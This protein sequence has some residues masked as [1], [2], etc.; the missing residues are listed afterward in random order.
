MKCFNHPAVDA[1][2]LCKNCLKAVCRDCATEMELGVVCRGGCGTSASRTSM[3]A[4]AGRKGRRIGPFLVLF[5][6]VA[7]L[8]GGYAAYAAI[9][10]NLQQQKEDAAVALGKSLALKGAAHVQAVLAQ[11]LA[12][13]R[14]SA[15]DV[16]DTNYQLIPA[17]DPPKYH[18]RFDTFLDGAIGEFQD[19]LLADPRVVF[20]VAVDRNGYL[21]THNSKFAQ[22]LTGNY[23]TDRTGNRTKRLFDDPVG[24]AAAKSRQEVLVQRYKRDTGMMMCDIAVPIYLNEQHWGAF[25]VGVEVR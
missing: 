23:Q 21:P 9:T 3:A 6:V 5:A 2:A 18:T 4:G 19:T 10:R 22:P 14:L 11:A 12:D 1:V 16:F 13:G 25:R 7:L 8:I 17:T 15:E 24:L 20:A